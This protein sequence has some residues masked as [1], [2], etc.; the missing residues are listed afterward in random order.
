MTAKV[1]AEISETDV[2]GRFPGPP[3]AMIDTHRWLFR[4]PARHDPAFLKSILIKQPRA[5][6]RGMLSYKL[7]LTM[8]PSHGKC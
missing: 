4:M 2:A 5:G 8:H 7:H 3:T 6:H 1:D